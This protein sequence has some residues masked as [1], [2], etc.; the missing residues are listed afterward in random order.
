MKIGMNG[1]STS[2]MRYKWGLYNER[3][4]EKQRVVRLVSTQLVSLCI[5]CSHGEV[6]GED[7]VL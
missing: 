4:Y 7:H 3:E 5:L 6:Q 1:S 2:D